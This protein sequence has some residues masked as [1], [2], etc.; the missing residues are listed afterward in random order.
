MPY[1]RDRQLVYSNCCLFRLN[2]AVVCYGT[3]SR[4]DQLTRYMQHPK[5][6]SVQ[7]FAF[8]FNCQH[9]LRHILQPSTKPTRT[10]FYLNWEMEQGGANVGV[11][12]DCTR[13]KPPTDGVNRQAGLLVRPGDA[14]SRPPAAFTAV[15][16]TPITFAAKTYRT[17]NAYWRSADILANLYRVLHSWLH[18]WLTLT[19]RSIRHRSIRTRV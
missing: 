9:E 14:L 18:V 19:C 11:R 17:L 15:A 3:S 7:T 4:E 10:K 2:G 1:K 8:T 12:N 6:A 5:Q 16:N 13:P